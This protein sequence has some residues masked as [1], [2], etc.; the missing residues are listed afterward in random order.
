MELV[1]MNRPTFFLSSTIYDFSD[2][3]ASVKY[4]LEQQGCTVLASEFN[5]FSKPIEPHSY[6]ACFNAI[7]KADY[8]VLFIGSRVGGWFDKIN[9]ISITQQEYKEAYKLHKLGKLKI[10]NFVRSDVWQLK[11][12]RTALL[13]YLDGLEIDPGAKQ[14][15]VNHPSKQ[16][17]NA[18]FII[19]FINEVG[20]NDET[21]IA[22]DN[23]G[24]LPTGNWIHTFQTFSDVI[25][26][27]QAQIFLGQPIEAVALKKLLRRELSEILRN[28]LI[29]MK[30][31][32]FSPKSTI[33]CFYQ[34]HTIT[35]DVRN[36]PYL[37]I[38]TKRWSLMSAVAMHLLTVR[39]HTLILPNALSSLIF[40]NY[41]SKTGA[42]QEE[43]IYEALF[44]LNEE[45]REFNRANTGDRLEVIF[46]NSRRARPNDYDLKFID[47]ETDKVLL[48][49]GLYMRWIN[50]I[51]LSK[52]IIRYLD[53]EE[54]VMPKLQ[55]KSPIPEM[56]E[57]IKK[58][59]VTT[60]EVDDFIKN[61]V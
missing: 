18:E 27:L 37:H 52:S 50:V 14:Q 9:Q 19:K 48:L 4:F 6:E 33:H 59:M 55:Q 26:V 8:F 46:E 51:D 2:L 43:P 17:S 12:D 45:I 39:L 10:I 3:R 41:D 54:F 20:R 16:L 1:K 60:K 13:K 29:K 15:I 47:I 28:C 5:D 38:D 32:I 24:I 40:M 22:L 58:E 36:N 35:K 53:G 42:M 21:K 61:G 23:E 25:D 34:E 57:D 49:L 44:L 56:N 30:D 7:Q 11:E 31:Q